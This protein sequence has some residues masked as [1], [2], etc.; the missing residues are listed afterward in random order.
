MERQQRERRR[1]P[2][3][4]VNWPRI[5]SVGT[6]VLQV[7]L[8]DLASKGAKVHLPDRL[9][10]GTAVRLRLQPPQ[11]RPIEVEAIQWWTDEDGSTVFF[12]DWSRR[13]AP[14]REEPRG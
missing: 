13:G 6:R 8:L 4:R 14:S 7:D 2:R 9:E 11:G 10:E 3:A 12:I 5:L 1:R